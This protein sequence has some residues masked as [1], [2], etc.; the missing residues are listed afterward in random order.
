MKRVLIV[1]LS[2]GI[3]TALYVAFHAND[4]LSGNT[5]LVEMSVSRLTCGSCVENIRAAVSAIDGIST[6]ET[7]VAAARSAVTF[8]PEKVTA[9]RIAETVG[10][11]G[12]PATI[13][14]VRDRQGTLVSGV[15][16]EKYVAR[17]G[18][19]LIERE[20][21]DNLLQERIQAAEI[22]GQPVPI[23]TVYNDAWV[24]LLSQQLLLNAS[25]QFDVTIDDAMLEDRAR[26]EN[27]TSTGDLE[28]LRQS[29]VVE[30]YLAQ[31]YQGRQPNVIEMNNL[32]NKLYTNTSIDIFD[33]ELKRYLATGKSSGGCGGSCCG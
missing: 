4:A 14:T 15:N 20:T 16:T 18:T 6:I 13:L 11:A 10:A 27:I 25:E 28:K 32:L 31:Q 29:L 24:S 2:I 33:S 1:L 8:D 30:E 12:Y 3:T 17:V 23:K 19:R 22:S 26:Q 7:D 9:D 5:H 21:L